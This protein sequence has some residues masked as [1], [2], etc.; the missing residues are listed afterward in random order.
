[1]QKVIIQLIIMQHFS[2]TVGVGS[3]AAR[4]AEV[5]NCGAIPPLPHMS[6]WL[7]AYLFMHTDNFISVGTNSVFINF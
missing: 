6:S 2:F 7:D 5:K 4:P 1:M 3:T